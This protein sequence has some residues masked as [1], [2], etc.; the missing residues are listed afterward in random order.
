MW[1]NDNLSSKWLDYANIA[2]NDEILYVL[3]WAT[4]LRAG[5]DFM[6]IKLVNEKSVSRCDGDT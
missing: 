2:M 5:F 3:L 6:V 1:E 4:I